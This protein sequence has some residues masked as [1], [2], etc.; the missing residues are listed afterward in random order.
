MTQIETTSEVSKVREKQVAFG[1]ERNHKCTPSAKQIV[2]IA[3]LVAS[4]IAC[5]SHQQG[6]AA[7]ITLEDMS[8]NS[9][10]AALPVTAACDP[11]SRYA[12]SVLLT[13]E[14]GS[15][16]APS[17]SIT[18]FAADD[19]EPPVLGNESLI[20]STYFAGDTC[21]F[22]F[23]ILVDEDRSIW[24][25]GDSE[26]SSVWGY[27]NQADTDA[28][29]FVAHLTCD[30]TSVMGFMFFGGSDIDTVQC[31]EFDS[32]GNLVLL[33]LTYSADFPTTE[34]A[35]QREFAG[36]RDDPNLFVVKLTRGMELM[37]STFIG[38]SEA[39]VPRGLGFTPAG[40]IV[41]SGD[42]MSQD[43]PTTQNAINQTNN[44]PE[45]TRDAFVALL[46]SEGSSLEYST[47]IG[48][49]SHELAEGGFVDAV[50]RI[51]VWGKT[52]SANFP[53]VGPQG[54]FTDPTTGD[55]FVFQLEP[56]EVNGDDRTREENAYV[57]S[58]TLIIGGTSSDRAWGGAES[59][60]DGGVFIGGY[61]A[62]DDFPTINET[63]L[64]PEM[65]GWGSSGFLLKIDEDWIVSYSSYIGGSIDER[66]NCL[67][68]QDGVLYALGQTWS[69]DT[70]VTAGTYQDPSSHSSDLWILKFTADDVRL[71]YSSVVGGL[72]RDYAF[73]IA[74]SQSGTIYV[75][76][77]LFDPIFPTTPDA[78]QPDPPSG[79]PT[80]NSAFF[81]LYPVGPPDRPI[82]VWV[83]EEAEMATIHWASTVMCGGSVVEKTSVYRSN[84]STRSDATLIAELDGSTFIYSETRPKNQGDCYYAIS[85]SNKYGE[86]PLSKWAKF[87]PDLTNNGTN[88]F[89]MPW[90]VVAWSSGISLVVTVVIVT[91]RKHLGCLAA[92]FRKK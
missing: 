84:D 83:S 40:D 30:A 77:E 35:F 5:V 42:T 80:I 54:Y 52:F 86:G 34:G 78:I 65:P 3:F 31:M 81:E 27:N 76:A 12:P 64:F 7:T 4:L 91:Q 44:G 73:D 32:E 11:I 49:S 87:P 75:S 36:N 37:F 66:I 92:T 79:E 90:T 26:S 55:A 60:E 9:F 18:K 43:F 61:T 62:S 50:G 6:S 68:V 25:A 57:L 23:T 39:D 21:E 33:G 56:V 41:I 63:A 1:R 22:L 2:R 29:C 51:T 14:K 82:D 10:S 72:G 48:G 45:S 70:P 71:L 88:G 17:S 74:V 28:N 8:V 19:L 15:R 13:G 24:L 46:S 16:N 59:K 69:S 20:Y 67:L 58:H 85:L 47:M 53:Q 89:D 38:G